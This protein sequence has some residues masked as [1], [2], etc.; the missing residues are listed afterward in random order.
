MI[1]DVG[2]LLPALRKAQRAL[3][4]HQS[5]WKVGCISGVERCEGTAMTRDSTITTNAKQGAHS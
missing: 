5:S 1:R 4:L 2:A 3:T